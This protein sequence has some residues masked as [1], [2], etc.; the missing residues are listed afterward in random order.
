MSMSVVQAGILSLLQDRGRRGQH[1]LGLSNGG[2]LDGAAFHYCNR[3]LQNPVG[4]TAIE[5]SVGGLQLQAQ[6][7]T[8]V[9]FTGAPMPLS[10]NGAERA[11]WEVHRV[12]AGD[13][14]SMGFAKSGCRS[15]LGVAD[16]FAIEPSFGSTATVV[17]EHIGGLRGERLRAGDT[18]PCATVTARKHYYLAERDRPRYQNTLTVRV[19]PGYQ[20]RYFSR[21]EQRRFFGSTYRVS[22]R[23]DRMGYRL[24]GP[25][26]ACTIEGILSEGICFGAI[27]LPPD[28]QPIVLLNDRQTIG[29]YPKIGA[30]LSLDAARMSQ[31]RPGSSVHF[32]PI[33]PHTAH[34]ALRLAQRF[35]LQLPLQERPA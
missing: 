1:R 15:Y 3:L 11:L 21:V 23:C 2:P 24:E 10:I 8:F 14:I 13:T 6:V 18:L 32:A 19:I 26:I 27:Q 9:C 31:L 22:E 35:A 34:K 7:D 25:A 5:V 20:Q 30:A 17:R 28:G 29:G 4:S 33:T 12:S 16:G